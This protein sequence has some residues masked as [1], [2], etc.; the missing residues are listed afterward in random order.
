MSDEKKPFADVGDN[1]RHPADPDFEEWLVLDGH[2]VSLAHNLAGFLGD[3]NAAVERREARLRAVLKRVEWR[4]AGVDEPYTCCPV[5]LVENEFHPSNQKPHR[6]DC[7]LAQALAGAGPD[8]VNGDVACGLALDLGIAMGTVADLALM[9]EASSAGPLLVPFLRAKRLAEKEPL[10]DIADEELIGEA[11]RRGLV[12]RIV[13]A[14]MR[15]AAAARAPYDATFANRLN[16]V[17]ALL[18][19]RRAC[20]HCNDLPYH[21]TTLACP[22]C[23]IDR[24]GVGRGAG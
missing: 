19:E 15:G 1:N 12:L 6:P 17:A 7:A 13:A 14:G 24:H 11:N 9:L 22:E 2:R 18:A 4:G 21:G 23:G 8:Y 16:S 5:C 10:R 20:P 3:I